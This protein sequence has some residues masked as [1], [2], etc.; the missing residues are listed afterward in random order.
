[1][2]E[3][4]ARTQGRIRILTISNEAK[5]NAMEGDMPAE[6]L[7]QFDAADADP[8]IRVVVVTGAGDVAFCSGHDLKDIASGAHARSGL[9]EAPV[10]RPLSMKK[11][12][13]AFISGRSAPAGKRMGH[14]GAIIMG[15]VGTPESKLAAF[16]AVNV[17]V[18]DTMPQIMDMVKKALN[19]Q[20]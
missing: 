19:I 11:P 7:R 13:I 6:L 18:A 1:M 20:N 10:L 9:G 2:P 5:R 16:A 4:Q 3:I 8:A 15:N 12:V 17:P 14:A